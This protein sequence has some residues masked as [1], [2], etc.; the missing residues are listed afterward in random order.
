MQPNRIFAVLASVV[1][2]STI[3]ACSTTGEKLPASDTSPSRE[4]SSWCQ[5]DGPIGYASAD[6]AG[7]DDPGNRFDSDETVADIQTHNA[8]YRAACPAPEAATPQ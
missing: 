2:A 7:Q 5:G 3:S 1:L 8:R 6:E 4:T